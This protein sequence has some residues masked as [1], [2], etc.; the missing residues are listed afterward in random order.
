[1]SFHI[2]TSPL[3]VILGEVSIQVLLQFCNWIDCLPGVEHPHRSSLYIL[4]IKPFSGVSL[5]DMF[6]HMVG[7]LFILLM[8]YLA[9]QELFNLMKSHLFVLSFISL[10]LES[11]SAKDIAAW[12]I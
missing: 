10:A 4:E 8:F 9:M 7:S 11:I 6:P 2:P 3:Y 1:M 12:D 5:A